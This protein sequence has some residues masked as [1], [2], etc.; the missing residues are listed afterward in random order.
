MVRSLKSR[1]ELDR[2]KAATNTKHKSSKSSQAP[3][4][5]D[6]SQAL[7]KILRTR[8][9]RGY[10]DRGW[11]RTRLIIELAR[12]EKTHTHLGK[13]FGCSTRAVSHFRKRNEQEIAEAR[14]DITD[15]FVGIWAAQKSA[16]LSELE[17]DV[18]DCNSLIRQ[19]MALPEPD[20]DSLSRLWRAKQ[21]AV[22]LIAEELGQIPRAMDLKLDQKV[23]EFVIKGGVDM[24]NM[25]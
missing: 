23:L 13:Q 12:N 10:L 3:I 7:A 11:I 6:E 8:K 4:Q 9:A 1:E 21:K 14:Q 2:K 22:R 25:K 15:E 24:E 19:E 18:I 16:R 20:T 17:Q 5:V